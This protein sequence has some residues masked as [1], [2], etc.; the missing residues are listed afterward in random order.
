MSRANSKEKARE[1]M[2]GNHAPQLGE[3]PLGPHQEADPVLEE[4]PVDRLSDEVRGARP[5]SP[6]DHLRV[7]SSGNDQDRQI[8]AGRK[9][10]K[11]RADFQAVPPRELHVQDHQIRG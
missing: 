7:V 1:G 8:A 5:E 10:S 9:L 6:I 2:Y 3:G 4:L 11:L